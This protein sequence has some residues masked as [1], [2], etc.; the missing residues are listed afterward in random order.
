M[1][2]FNYV[3]TRDDYKTFIYERNKQYNIVYFIVA[4]ILYCLFMYKLLMDKPI[5]IGFLFVVYILIIMLIFKVYN[6]VFTF[7]VVKKDDN[8]MSPVYGKYKVIVDDD[9][10][11]EENEKLEEQVLWREIKKVRITDDYITLYVDY[12]RALFFSKNSLKAGNKFNKLIEIIKS[13][14]KG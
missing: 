14:T 10:I 13:K 12:N 11:Y 2:H 5:T 1:M 8:K 6:R 3:L 9:G 7:V 4:S